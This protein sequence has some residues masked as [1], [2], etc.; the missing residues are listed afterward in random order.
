M[1]LFFRQREQVGGVFSLA[2]LGAGLVLYDGKNAWEVI[3]FIAGV[4]CG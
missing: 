3:A 1:E 4:F 2:E